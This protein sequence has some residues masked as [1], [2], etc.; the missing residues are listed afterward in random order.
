MIGAFI[1]FAGWWDV[2]KIAGEVRDPERNLPR[3]L[4]L[5]VSI[6]T[7]V[8]IAVSVVFLYLVPPARIASDDTAFAALAGE[9]LFGRSRGDLSSRSSSI[10]SVA[11]SLAAVL[12]AFPRVY[13]AMARD[14]LF[15]R[16]RS[17]PSTRAGALPRGRLRSRPTLASLL[18]LSGTFDQILAY[19]MVPTM[20]FL[21]LTVGRGLR[22]SAPHGDSSPPGDAGLSRSLRCC[23]WSRSWS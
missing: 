23:S 17:R 15:F 22:P 13:Y 18:A 20:V 11:G 14:G 2:S 3:A 16:E 1:S 8:Y 7:V 21:A 12:M 10:V 6:V 19:F 9:A 4:M 5:G